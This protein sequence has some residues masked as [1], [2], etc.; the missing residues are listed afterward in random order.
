ML[1]KIHIYYG[2]TG[3]TDDVKFLWGDFKMWQSGLNFTSTDPDTK[4]LHHGHVNNID[5]K[6]TELVPLKRN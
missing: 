2:C 5:H 3:C 4:M 1:R 6:N